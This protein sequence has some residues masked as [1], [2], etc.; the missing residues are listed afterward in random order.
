MHLPLSS[1]AVL[2]HFLL[3]QLAD[4]SLF[5]ILPSLPDSNITDEEDAVITITQNN[6]ISYLINYLLYLSQ[7]A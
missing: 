5:S 2:F 4:L 6:I 3:L 1:T 7:F